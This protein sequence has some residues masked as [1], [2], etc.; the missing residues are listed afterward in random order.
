MAKKKK[1]LKVFVS[2]DFKGH[3]PVGTCALIVAEDESAARILLDKELAS[4]KLP[5]T[6]EYRITEVQTDVPVAEILL[7][8]NY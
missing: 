5:Q 7:D 8:G 2:T 6:E 1:K 4:R 3:Y